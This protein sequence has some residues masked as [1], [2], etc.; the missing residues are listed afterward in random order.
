M[1]T[2]FLGL[3]NVCPPA[4]PGPRTVS[5]EAA[6]PAAPGAEVTAHPTQQVA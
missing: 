1:R 5:E 3:S 4:V 6:L 2:P